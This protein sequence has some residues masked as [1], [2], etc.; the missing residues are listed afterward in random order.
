M[1]IGL[2]GASGLFGSEFSL[3]AA[4]LGHQIQAISRRTMF[5]R[6]NDT[7]DHLISECDVIVHAAANTNVEEC[8]VNEATCYRDNFLLSEV[9]ARKAQKANK[10][11]VFLSSTGVYGEALDT[12]YRE[13]DSAHPTTVHHRSKLLAERAIK[14]T[15]QD[16]L[17][18]RTGWLFGGDPKKSKNFVTQRIL[19]GQ[20][21]LKLGMP[22]HSNS[23]Q[24][25][26]PTS[27]RDLSRRIEELII[28]NF[29]GVFN[30]VNEGNTSRYDY[31]KEILKLADLDVRLISVTPEAFSRKANVSSNEMAINW[32]MTEMG[33]PKMPLWK[34]SLK[35]YIQTDLN[36]G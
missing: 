5:E 30:C 14:Y 33:M 19:E 6:C 9:L 32:R 26:N 24:R 8:E 35:H 16:Y 13:F 4:E 27:V 29:R 17:I 22:I 25:G 7:I 31:V 23:G 34:E 10:K 3:V 36:L 21:A 12:P 2:T 1:R 18:I 15:L 28:G 20:S 11:L